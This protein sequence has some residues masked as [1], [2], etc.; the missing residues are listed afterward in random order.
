MQ[1][2]KNNTKQQYDAKKRKKHNYILIDWDCIFHCDKNII[3]KK[4][5]EKLKYVDIVNE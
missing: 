3:N 4:K 2:K 5:E 1:L